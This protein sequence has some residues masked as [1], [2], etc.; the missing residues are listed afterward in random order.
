MC[1]I[2]GFWPGVQ[3]DVPV[4]RVLMS[5]GEAIH[6]RG[7]DAV[8]YWNSPV[9]AA[10]VHRRLSVMDLTDAGS[11]P[12][13]STSRRYTIIYNG[14]TYNHLQIRA[15]LEG[16]SD[17]KIAWRGHSDTETILQAVEVWGIEE[18][19][20][21]LIGMFAIALWDHEKKCL[22]LARDRM[23]EKPLYYGL[24]KGAL[25]FGSQ[26]SA[27]RRYPGF[28]A[29]PDQDAM[30]AFLRFSC[31]PEPNSI[32][33]NIKKV[34]PGTCL[35]FSQPNSE[36]R[37][38]TY[39]SLKQVSSVEQRD[40][41]SDFN[42]HSNLIEATL[43]DVIES[44]MLSDVP[45]GC[46]MSGGVDSTLVAALMKQRS[47][48]AV[49]TFSMG[50]SDSRF[51]EAHRAKEVANFLGTEH[52]EFI[53]TEKDVL[54]IIPDLPNI[55]DEPFADSSQLPTVLLSRLTRE[56]VTVAL[57]GDGADELFG[58]YNRH[59]F[60]PK[61]WAAIGVL[62]AP[63]RRLI[64]MAAK[65]GQRFGTSRLGG[66]LSDILSGVGL[67][68][69]SVSRLSKFGSSIENA[70]SLSEFYSELV[71]V[72]P[73]SNENLT[74]VR[75]QSGFADINCGL[76]LKNNSERMMYLDSLGYLPDDILVKV[77]RASMSCSLET[78]APFLDARMVE[79][80]WKVPVDMKIR[81]RL[82]KVVLR[83][84]LSRHLPNKLTNHP[85][86]GF[87]VPLDSWLRGSLKEWA[88]DVLVDQSLEEMGLFEKNTISRVWNEHCSGRDNHGS[89]LWNVLMLQGWLNNNDGQSS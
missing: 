3:S 84:I 39:W 75:K 87:A 19:L 82:G 53:V 34:R 62:P 32:F 76:H 59:I 55:Y 48:G 69:T 12:M 13:H 2:A 10:F 64:G 88:N 38:H 27:I 80:A 72:W 46:F 16:Y 71:T 6:A 54:N 79:A 22:T 86:Q 40:I 78:R 14:E 43:G 35:T 67:P 61:V 24:S 5:M 77:D 30:M 83:D 50:F 57:S 1:G 29:T 70:E 23:G 89:K 65:G 68:V 17:Q 73:H 58:G 31:V 26:L 47:A 66:R 63:A 25:V 85:K 56:S 51:N 52:T 18:T 9:G 37:N 42:T 4:D 21:R 45:L 33:T 7:P 8:G 44:Q 81:K 49:H 41:H 11:Q 60:G 28:D 15:D 36:P 20:S 74:G